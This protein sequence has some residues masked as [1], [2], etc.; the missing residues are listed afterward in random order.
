MVIAVLSALQISNL[1]DNGKGPAG[2]TRGVLPASSGE[3][4]GALPVSGYTK[5]GLSITRGSGL[6]APSSPYTL[7]SEI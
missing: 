3:I 4:F 2:S 5:P 6:L 1:R 7:V